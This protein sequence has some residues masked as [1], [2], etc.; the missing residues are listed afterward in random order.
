MGA[1]SG[2]ASA[3]PAVVDPLAGVDPHAG[4]DP[5]GALS[6]FSDQLAA[7]SVPADPVAAIDLSPADLFQTLIYDP[8]HGIGAGM[9]R[10][11]AW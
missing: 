1:A 6:V 10:Q 2:V 11:P 3:L 9:D 8:I 4:L 7:V 5:A